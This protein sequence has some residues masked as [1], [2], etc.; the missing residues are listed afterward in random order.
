MQV[1]RLIKK[2]EDGTYEGKLVLSQAQVEFLIN[3]A[4]GVLVQSGLATII[5]KEVT[6]ESLDDADLVTQEPITMETLN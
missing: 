3:V 4:L 1:T 5:E 2:Q 6:L